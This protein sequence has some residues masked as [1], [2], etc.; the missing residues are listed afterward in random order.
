[1]EAKLKIAHSSGYIL[2]ILG[3]LVVVNYLGTKWFK[4][5]DMTEGKEYSISASTKKI[6]K[7]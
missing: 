3:L 1:M 6:L 5:I 4:R 2:V 7:T